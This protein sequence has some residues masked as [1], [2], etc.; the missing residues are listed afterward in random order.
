MDGVLNKNNRLFLM[1]DLKNAYFGNCIIWGTSSVEFTTIQDDKHEFYFVLDKCYIKDKDNTI[2]TQDKTHFKNITRSGDNDP[3]FKSIE[4]NK[5]DFRLKKTSGSKIINAGSIDI[6][7]PYPFDFDQH[8]RL[9][10]NAPDLGAF[11]Y[12]PE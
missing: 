5:Y 9:N 4:E 11:E 6:A 7:S 10:D 8:S 3:G 1:P 2:N 12:I